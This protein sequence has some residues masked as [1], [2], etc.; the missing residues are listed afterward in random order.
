MKPVAG[1]FA[2]LSLL[3]SATPIESSSASN[4]NSI[5]SH[6]RNANY[7]FNSLHSSMRQWG[8]AW[9][10][11]GMSFYL[12]SV[13]SGTQFYHGTQS[14]DRVNGTE[15]L[16]FEPEHALNFARP[17]HGRGPG[18]GPGGGPPPGG[19]PPPPPF[20]MRKEKMNKGK[21]EVLL[22][23]DKA[24]NEGQREE[25]EEEW[26]Y[27]HTYVANKDL[28]LL[29]IDGLS[30][31][32]TDMGTT[33]SGDRIFLQDRNLTLSD[34]DQRTHQAGPGG[35][36]AR[37]R[38]GCEI[39]RN[40]WNDRIDGVLRAE[41]GFEI[42][43]CDFARDLDVVRINAVKKDDDETFPAGFGN[44]GY[45]YRS[46]AARF[47]GIG[48]E[49][50]KI[51]YDN[52]I[53]AFTYEELD[54]FNGG[55]NQMP[56]LNHF[57]TEELQPIRDD[58][59]RFVMEHETT[60]ES[61]FNWQ[62]IV[63]MIVT[64]Y[65]NLLMFFASDEME[66]LQSLQANITTIFLAFIDG[67]RRDALAETERCATQFIAN[68]NNNRL[69]PRQ[70][71]HKGKSLA[72]QVV[73][74]VSY[75]ICSTLRSVLDDT[76]FMV[77]TSRITNLIEYLAW[78]TWKECKTKCAYNQACFIPIWP[79]G[80]VQDRLDPQCKEGEDDSRG[81]ERYWRGGFGGGKPREDGWH[82]E[83]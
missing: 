21:Q 16:A 2:T 42:I 53:T 32:K 60:E 76:D 22:P 33:D 43:L 1:V 50:V 46:I 59:T 41:A 25:E 35:E 79:F 55:K 40:D 38:I 45:F 15:W 12:A 69:S 14:A 71:V 29:Y 30:A 9:H 81:G 48:G 82:E 19:P 13:P 3:A 28:R 52:F 7:I 74:D 39:A 34:N 73:Y 10:H 20:A 37:A 54:L 8:S 61:S 17:R 11:N 51:N 23:G 63:D 57:S 56:R 58:L 83:L 78:T 66:S 44:S 6:V 24:D 5:T 49:R 27:L 31:G 47:D 77:A 68:P 70:N 4:S 72:G 64:K 18:K 65:S 26:G 62:S 36:Y 80:T 67:R 75:S